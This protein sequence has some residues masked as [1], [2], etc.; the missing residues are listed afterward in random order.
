MKRRAQLVGPDG[1]PVA[2]KKDTE[3]PFIRYNPA[4]GV[5]K[6][7]HTIDRGPRVYAEALLFLA[8]GGRF[9]CQMTP[10][11]K[12]QAIAGFPVRGGAEGEMAIVAEEITENNPSAIGAGVDRL[13]AAAVRDMDT[14]ILGESQ[15]T[16][17]VQ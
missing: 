17:T 14:V 4:P 16:E 2:S 8:R 7:L 12:H 5:K 13:V 15:R 9:V 6:G 1:M 11:G 3:I 10:W